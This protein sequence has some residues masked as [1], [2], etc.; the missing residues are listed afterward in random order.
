MKVRRLLSFLIILS[1]LLMVGPAVASA[2]QIPPPMFDI[3]SAED[4]KKINYYL[5]LEYD[6]YNPIVF[7]LMNDIE[8]T[9]ENWVPIGTVNRPFREVFDGRNHT[10]TFKGDTKF[11]TP[12]EHEFNGYGL[13]GN[14]GDV[15]IYDLTVILEG[16]LTSE[17]DNVAALV[18]RMD[19]D[20]LIDVDLAYL[21]I[22]NCTVQGKGYT[23][24][25]R[26]NVGGLVGNMLNG[27]VINC[28]SDVSVKAS[29]DNAGGLIGFLNNT[30][31][32]GSIINS[33]ASGSVEADGRNAGGLIGSINRGNISEA[34]VNVSVTANEYAGALV[35]FVSN[36]NVIISNSSANGSVKPAGH[37][38]N[39]IGGWNE[40][41]KPKVV[42][43]YYRGETV[44]LEPVPLEP[45]PD[46][47]AD[48]SKTYLIAIVIGVF[49]II[50][51][52]AVYFKRRNE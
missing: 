21:R 19:G 1:L 45:I 4:L 29:E 2:W 38:G 22:E 24:N 28:S 8:I 14:V 13:F 41:Y 16:N 11:V 7:R 18:G 6:L 20:M 5:D 39:F 15:R 44:D 27:S 25:G 34:S 40:N 36:E 17:H 51:G 31:I 42:N 33:S 9:E 10:I 37:F 49:L 30:S 46:P 52:V 43:C 48:N 47:I 3:Y 12:D 50:A 32:N 35:G 26:N 23:I